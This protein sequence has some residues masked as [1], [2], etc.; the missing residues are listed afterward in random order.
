MSI[1]ESVDLMGL[2]RA[3]VTPRSRPVREEGVT[4]EPFVAEGDRDHIY[5]L[6]GKDTTSLE[7][8][9]RRILRILP[10]HHCMEIGEAIAR[11]ELSRSP[12]HIFL[13]AEHNPVRDFKA[14][15]LSTLE[16]RGTYSAAQHPTKTHE[17]Y[18]GT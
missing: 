11:E 12:E 6:T 5:I 1:V 4:M 18:F 15:Y 16:K 8:A 10:H 2:I 17:V 7:R 13:D 14:V 9:T 3:G